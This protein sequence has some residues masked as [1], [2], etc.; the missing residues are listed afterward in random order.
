[1]RSA[2]RKSSLLRLAGLALLIPAAGMLTASYPVP[3]RELRGRTGAQCRPNEP[4]PAFRLTVS[5]LKDRK[6]KLLLEL[7]PANDSDFLAADKKL[8]AE[9]KP[10]LR[11][12]RN[13]P[14]D[15]DPVLCIRAPEPGR[16]ALVVLHDRD[17]NGKFSYLR[18]GV[19][20]PGN[21][22]LVRS[23]PKATAASLVAQGGEVSEDV[24]MQ[25]LRG[26]RFRPVH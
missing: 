7:Y 25:Y 9:G 6:G 15:G 11:V 14:A 22:P 2:F 12:D 20:F 13:I 26:L 8:I 4:G 23:K 1:M 17:G 24:T 10:F 5:G 21:P 18:D 19:A 16:F 3:P